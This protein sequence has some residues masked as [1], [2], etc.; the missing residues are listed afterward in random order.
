MQVSVLYIETNNESNKKTFKNAINKK[1][2]A[3]NNNNLQ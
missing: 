3:Y 2:R 1:T